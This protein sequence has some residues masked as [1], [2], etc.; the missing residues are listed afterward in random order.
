M[1]AWRIVKPKYEHSAFTGEG[2]AL[3][4]GRWNS[5][6]VW[7]VYA[8]ATRSLATLELLVH[9]NPP[10]HQ[11]Y[12]AFRITFEESMVERLDRRYLKPEWRSE[13]P[14]PSTKLLGDDWI[15]RAST[16]VLEVP[17]AIIVGECN[18]LLNPAHPEFYKVDCRYSERFC[19]DPRLA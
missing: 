11:Y 2:A 1:E 5:K 16:P 4:G 13:P 14:S 3:A 10:I 17:S 7:M 18:Y 19:L 8:S 12:L 9:L 15:R 6:G